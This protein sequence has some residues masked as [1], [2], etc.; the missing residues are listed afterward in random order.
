MCAEGGTGH[1]QLTNCAPHLLAVAHVRKDSISPQ[2]GVAVSAD[3][4]MSFFEVRQWNDSDKKAQ[5]Q[6]Q[7][8]PSTCVLRII[9]HGELEAESERERKWERRTRARERVLKH[10]LTT[11][12]DP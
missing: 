11:A 10:D 8:K 7:I 9:T 6:S 4:K 2:R 12:T 1:W 3:G 5:G